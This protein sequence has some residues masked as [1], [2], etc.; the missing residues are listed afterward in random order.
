M[1]VRL[2]LVA[3]SYCKSLMLSVLSPSKCVG[4][5]IIISAGACGFLLAPAYLPY[6]KDRG[7]RQGRGA[8]ILT[9]D[10]FSWLCYFP[11]R[12][13]KVCRHSGIYIYPR[14]NKRADNRILICVL[15]ALRLCVWL[16]DNCGIQMFYID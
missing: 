3:H 10:G 6:S 5:N 14:K 2:F 15:S 16:F 12:S 11:I 8:F 4:A 1:N 13:R 9:L 7:S